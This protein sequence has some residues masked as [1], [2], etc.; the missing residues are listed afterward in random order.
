MCSMGL[1]IFRV[2]DAIALTLSASLTMSMAH[3]EVGVSST[4]TNRRHGYEWDVGSDRWLQRHADL[5]SRAHAIRAARKASAASVPAKL[6]SS[7][8]CVTG[9]R[10]RPRSPSTSRRAAGASQ[11]L[12]RYRI[13][14]VSLDPQAEADVEIAPRDYTATVAIDVM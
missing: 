4:P 2:S 6:W 7:W 5:Q 11:S 13:E 8:S 9:A 3:A 12:Q 14:I 10:R 1:P